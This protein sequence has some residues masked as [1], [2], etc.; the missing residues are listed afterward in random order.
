[1]Q[2]VRLHEV[3]PLKLSIPSATHSL[4]PRIEGAIRNGEILV[5]R[6]ISIASLTAG[7]EF[8]AQTDWSS[9]LP[10]WIGLKELGNDRVTVNPIIEPQLR[11]ELALSHLVRRPLSRPAQLVYEYFYEELKRSE[12]EWERMLG[13]V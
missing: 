10:Y 11:V 12:S 8:V 1:M 6:T 4:R 2:P 7:L 13:Q 3:V 5:D 9:I